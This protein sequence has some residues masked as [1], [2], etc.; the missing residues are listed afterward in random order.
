MARGKSAKS[1]SKAK[2]GRKGKS[3]PKFDPR[4]RLKAHRKPKRGNDLL[5]S[6]SDLWAFCTRLPVILSVGVLLGFCIGL[7]VA[8]IDELRRGRGPTPASETTANEPFE[9]PKS[10][11]QQPDLVDQ[12]QTA[13]AAPPAAEPAPQEEPA[14]DTAGTGATAAVEP[15]PLYTEETEP[16]A[17]PDTPIAASPPKAA[18]VEQPPAIPEPAPAESAAPEPAPPPAKPAPAT[19]QASQEP[20]PAAAEEPGPELASMLPLPAPTPAAPPAPAK[21]A[22]AEAAPVTAAPSPAPTPDIAIEP[23]ADAPIEVA[24]IEA[25]PLTAAPLPENAPTWLKNA[26]ASIDP[27]QR[28]MIAIVLD[29]VGVAP[30]DAELALKLPSPVTLSIM[31]Y[32]SN[33]ATLAQRARTGG[34]EIMVHMPMEPVDHSVDPGPNALLVGLT[35][36]EI[37]RR[38]IWGL[39][40]FD[41]YVG[42]NKHMGSRF[43]QYA[44]GMQIVMDELK[45]RGLLFLDSRTIGN[46]VGEATAAKDGVTH[47]SRDVFLDNTMSVDA[48]LKQLKD[49]EAVARAQ[50]YVVAIGH[51]HPTTVAALKRWI[52]EARRAGFVLVP[53]SEIVKK[54]EGLAG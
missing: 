40:Q 16:N 52:P 28:P 25:A 4:V 49:A 33:A 36:A 37:R 13:E 53:L 2:S 18:A 27:G 32:A 31:T 7:T 11:A 51:P 21:T 23:S 39:S 54:R 24:P 15:A 50:G 17:A 29:D 14:A 20:A 22:P 19:V 5:A 38:V 47:I 26:V 9:A 35:E 8:E 3:A 45:S 34:H 42:I 1:K 6:A 44:P 12:N 43:T 10:A 41:G 48:V 30:A 46:S